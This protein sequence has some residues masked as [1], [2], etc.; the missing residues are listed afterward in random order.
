MNRP[1][2][3]PVA[4]SRSVAF[5]IASFLVASAFVG[6]AIA[7]QVV[8]TPPPRSTETTPDET[9][10]LSP[11]EVN[12]E[13]DTGYLASTAQSGTRLRT[14]LKDIASSISG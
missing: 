7:Q 12:S 1:R 14:E 9:L 5:R 11:F 8:P 2:C 6:S 13:A 4:R 10:V 3:S